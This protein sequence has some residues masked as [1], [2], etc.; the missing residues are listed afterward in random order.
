MKIR[1]IILSIV[2]LAFTAS[3]FS[4]TVSDLFLTAENGT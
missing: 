1:R 2:I 3:F 4:C